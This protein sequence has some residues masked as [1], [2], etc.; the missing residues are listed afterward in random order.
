MRM[1][2]VTGIIV[3]W[4]YHVDILSVLMMRMNLGVKKQVKIVLHFPG[5]SDVNVNTC[6][7]MA[8]F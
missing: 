1:C 4:K 3:R 6:L 7:E 2:C 5:M 8:G